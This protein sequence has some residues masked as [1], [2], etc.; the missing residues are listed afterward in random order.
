MNIYEL[1]KLPNVTFEEGLVERLNINDN[2]EFVCKDVLVN[3]VWELVGCMPSW[4]FVVRAS[5]HVA[6][7]VHI[8]K[9]DVFQDGE[10]IGRLGSTWYRR[11]YCVSIGGGKIGEYEHHR[12]KD[13]HKAV[14]LAKKNFKKKDIGDLLDAADNESRSVIRTAMNDMQR[15][16]S[17]SFDR[18]RPHLIHF[19]LAEHREEFAAAISSYTQATE[20]LATWTDT[21]KDLVVATDMDMAYKAR[22]FYLVIARNGQYIVRFADDSA[23]IYD[24]GNFPDNLRGKL[25]LLKLITAGQMVSDV[26]C[27][28]NDNTFVLLKEEQC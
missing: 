14:L 26:G 1:V 4:R 6:T 17:T 24:D 12:T 5:R 2:T 13:V 22:K 16:V 8:E 23:N 3:T 9:F 25:G 10:H 28:V 11:N 18:L 15:R 27:R 7:A 21:D 19:A 20:A